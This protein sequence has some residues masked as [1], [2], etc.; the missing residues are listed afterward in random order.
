MKASRKDKANA[1]NHL[2]TYL[3][4]AYDILQL[5]SRIRAGSNST[6]EKILDERAESNKQ[7]E[8]E[9][10]QCIFLIKMQVMDHLESQHRRVMEN[11]QTYTKAKEDYI[12]LAEGVGTKEELDAFRTLF[13]NH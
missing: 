6:I 10:A 11:I 3:G 4:L 13:G 12:R 9:I 7:E 5:G 8:V 2:P 1:L